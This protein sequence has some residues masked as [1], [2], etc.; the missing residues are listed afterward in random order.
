[1]C[2]T[3]LTVNFREILMA[4]ER[5]IFNMTIDPLILN[6][7]RPIGSKR[8]TGQAIEEILIAHFKAIGKL[9]ADYEPIGELRGAKP[10]TIIGDGDE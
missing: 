1:M 3:V 8:K 9:P 6:L 2:Y 7:A 5:K 10:K 4:R